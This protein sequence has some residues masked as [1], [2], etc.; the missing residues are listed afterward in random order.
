MRQ[1]IYGWVVTCVGGAALFVGSHVL[2]AQN[3][4]DQQREAPEIR[5]LSFSG[6]KNVDLNDLQKSIST[7]ATNTSIGSPS[8][9]AL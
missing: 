4:R 2:R 6:V 5:K 3:T 7:R 1:S 9:A 8:H